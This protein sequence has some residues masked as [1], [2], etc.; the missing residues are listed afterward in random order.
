MSWIGHDPG[1]YIY[2]YIYIYM[3]LSRLKSYKTPNL[4][5]IKVN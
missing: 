4:D 3:E 2:I 1:V 5:L